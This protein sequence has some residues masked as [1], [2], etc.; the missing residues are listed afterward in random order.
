[1]A[2][3]VVQLGA[4]S[5]SQLQAA[6]SRLGVLDSRFPISYD[7]VH[8]TARVAGPRRYVEPSARLSRR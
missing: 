5:A 2:S 7:R 6:L 1:M 4:V 8:D 3:E